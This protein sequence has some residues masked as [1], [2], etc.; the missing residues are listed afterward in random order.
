MSCT[1][2]SRSCKERITLMAKQA[3]GFDFGTSNCT[4]SIY[5]PEKG[6]VETLPI[7]NYAES[8]KRSLA[9][10][11]LFPSKVGLNKDF[12]FLFGDDTKNCERDF[13]WDNSKRLLEHNTPIY[14]GGVYKKPIWVAIGIMAGIF[15]ELK[16]LSVKTSSPMVITVPANSYSTQRSLT[17]LAAESFN[18][19]V[20]QLVSEPCAAALGCY[21]YIENL[22]HIL[23]VDVGG[24]TTDIALI[25]N[26]FG[27]LKEIAIEGLKRFGGINIDQKL[28]EM[29]KDEFELSTDSEKLLFRDLLEDVKIELSSKKIAKLIFNDK[30]VE[31]TRE[32]VEKLIKKDIESLDKAIDKVLKKGK[33]EINNVEAV[34]PIG[35]SSNIPAVRNLLKNKFKSKLINLNFDESIT[36]VAKGAALASAINSKIVTNLRFQQC[37]EHSVGLRIWSGTHDNKIFKAM[38]KKGSAFPASA[39]ETYI[40]DTDE[41][42]VALYESTSGKLKN[43]DTKLIIEKKIKT[44]IMH[45]DVELTYDDDGKIDIKTYNINKGELRKLGDLG[46]SDKD[47][48]T[49]LKNLQKK[50]R[51]KGLNLRI[52]SIDYIDSELSEKTLKEWKNEFL[53]EHKRFRKVSEK[54]KSLFKKEVEDELISINIE[55]ISEVINEEKEELD[56]GSTN[57]AFMYAEGILKYSLRIV[58]N[59]AGYEKIHHFQ[60]IHNLLSEHDVIYQTTQK[61]LPEQPLDDIRWLIKVLQKSRYLNNLSHTNTQEIKVNL[62]SLR[63]ILNKFSHGVRSGFFGLF[64][65]SLDEYDSPIESNILNAVFKESKYTPQDVVLLA[66]NVFSLITSLINTKVYIGKDRED[67]I[68]MAE[69]MLSLEKTYRNDF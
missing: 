18:F 22:K 20:N 60:S 57:D 23:I 30:V 5:D 14:R 65:D 6:I 61:L 29:Y 59:S 55:D 34:L 1:G 12:E 27:T 17:R 37:L 66:T 13:V 42:I 10:Q 24:G 50:S 45:V 4:V 53:G 21:S 19:N 43:N 67:L 44:G 49:Y 3:L 8:K 56:I 15:K 62:E 51:E 7:S 58:F 40:S 32:N 52:D 35:G 28:Y 31:I 69:S 25:E 68:R 36:A 54:V 16:N 33:I 9:N 63:T 38:L 41:S 64:T 47:S 2:I 11:S 46:D 26:D 39:V 48:H